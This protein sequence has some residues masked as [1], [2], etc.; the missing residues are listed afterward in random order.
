MN[1]WLFSAPILFPNRRQAQRS[2]SKDFV[3]LFHFGPLIKTKNERISIFIDF[4]S[5]YRRAGISS[6]VY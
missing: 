3:P 5:F 4:L 6:E 2:N 1:Y